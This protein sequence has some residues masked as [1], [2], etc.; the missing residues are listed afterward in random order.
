LARRH[1]QVH[2]LIADALAADPETDKDEALALADEIEESLV[3]TPFSLLFVKRNI[4]A[5][6]A[7]SCSILLCLLTLVTWTQYALHCGAWS[8]YNAKAKTI[9]FNVSKNHELRNQVCHHLHKNDCACAMF[10]L[11][12]TTSS[13]MHVYITSMP[14]L[15]LSTQ[16][17]TGEISAAELAVMDSASMAS[18]EL[19]QRRVV[20]AEESLKVCR[21]PFLLICRKLH[22]FIVYA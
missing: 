9:K 6:L 16:I 5:L 17:L 13:H 2:K 4:S 8:E 3:S 11:H 7:S 10:C 21:S 1:T 20:A 15:T 14:R 19:R 18:S 22:A 12:I